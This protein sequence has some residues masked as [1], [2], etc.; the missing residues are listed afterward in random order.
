VYSKNLKTHP[1]AVVVREG[2]KFLV[3]KA[4]GKEYKISKREFKRKYNW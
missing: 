3:L 4:K 1:D 2:D